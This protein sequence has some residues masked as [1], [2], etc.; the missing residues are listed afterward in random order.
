MLQ[1]NFFESF[2]LCSQLIE[3]EQMFRSDRFPANDYISD[4]QFIVF[5]KMTAH[6]AYVSHLLTTKELDWI[7]TFCEYVKNFRRITLR[8]Y[9][10]IQDIYDKHET[11][12]IFTFRDKENLMN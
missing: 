9:Q 6:L 8:Q 5:K 11:E 12:I 10:V 7:K 2:N 3:K 1:Q 4:D